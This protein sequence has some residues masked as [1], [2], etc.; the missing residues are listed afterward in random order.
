MF[1]W[2]VYCFVDRSC[3]YVFEEMR[4][5]SCIKEDW[6]SRMTCHFLVNWKE[7][8][9]DLFFY[10]FLLWIF[11][12]FSKSR[13]VEIELFWILQLSNI[14]NLIVIQSCNL[15]W[16]IDCFQKESKCNDFWIKKSNQCICSINNRDFISILNIERDNCLIFIQLRVGIVFLDCFS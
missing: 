1:L 4:S 9:L 8:D 3:F 5:Y 7:L 6:W 2:F 11:V 15:S 16:E 14:K 12:G 10:R 13:G